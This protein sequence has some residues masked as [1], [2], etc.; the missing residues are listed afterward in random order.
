MRECIADGQAMQPDLLLR[1]AGQGLGSMHLAD[2]VVSVVDPT[3]ISLRRQD[4]SSFRAFR[5]RHLAASTSCWP[6]PSLQ[7]GGKH[8]GDRDRTHRRAALT[9]SFKMED[10]LAFGDPSAFDGRDLCRQSAG[11]VGPSAGSTARPERA[12]ADAGFSRP[13]TVWRSRR[14]RRHGCEKAS[15]RKFYIQSRA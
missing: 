10:G 3:I 6:L 1:A 13:W 4:R 11:G 5:K 15:S 14:G 8:H 7:P 9:S 12:V 2:R